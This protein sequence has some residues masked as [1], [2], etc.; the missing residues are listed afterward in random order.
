VDR[1][2]PARKHKECGLENVLG[3]FG[4]AEDAPRHT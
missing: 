3:V 2:S 4:V 1:A